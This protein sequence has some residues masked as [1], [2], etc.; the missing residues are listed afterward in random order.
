MT[1][2]QLNLPPADDES[3]PDLRGHYEVVARQAL[4]AFWRHKWLSAAMVVL[5]VAIALIGLVLVEPHYTAEVIIEPQFMGVEARQGV[6]V[7]PIASLDPTALVESQ[8]R[9]IRSRAVAEAVV[10]RLGLDSNPAFTSQSALGREVMAVRATFGL[11]KSPPTARD[12]AENEL[13]RRVQVKNE[14][15]SYLIS[16]S[17]SSADPSMSPLLVD[18]VALEYL[19]YRALEEITA[20]TIAADRELAEVASVFGERHPKFLRARARAEG[21]RSVAD[22][23]RRASSAAEVIRLAPGPRILLAGRAGVLSGPDITLVIG[24]SAVVGLVVGLWMSHRNA[25]RERITNRS[26]AEPRHHFSRWH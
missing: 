9:L 22:A 10:T 23:L 18:T 11:Q 17:A 19:R 12:L 26:H 8:I 6:I 20:T 13:M 4:S 7:G 2:S 15:R 21:V 25:S 1:I 3:S 16:I 5:A 24:L 14:P